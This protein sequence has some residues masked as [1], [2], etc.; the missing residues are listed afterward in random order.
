MEP[1]SSAEVHVYEARTVAAMVLDKPSDPTRQEWDEV[2]DWLEEHVTRALDEARL[3]LQVRA[4]AARRD[5]D[6]AAAN[7]PDPEGPF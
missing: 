7:E 4:V 5:S 1:Y 3:Q 2:G 6:T